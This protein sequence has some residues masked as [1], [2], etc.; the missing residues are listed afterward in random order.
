MSTSIRLSNNTAAA[1]FVQLSCVVLFIYSFYLSFSYEAP[2]RF[3]FG[4]NFIWLYFKFLNTIAAIKIEFIFNNKHT[5]NIQSDSWRKVQTKR[6]CGG[7]F[8]KTIYWNGI[9]SIA[10]LTIW[11]I[12]I[13]KSISNK[14]QVTSSHQLF[15]LFNL[16]FTFL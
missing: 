6:E 9:Q 3:E 11:Y 7:R 2:H 13:R 4:L 8:Y 5:L 16:F 10:D 1:V 14:E 12:Q 15:I